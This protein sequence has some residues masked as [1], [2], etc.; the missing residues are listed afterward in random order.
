M[1]AMRTS[2][3]LLKAAPLNI[4]PCSTQISPR[5]TQIAHRLLQKKK[6][7]LRC[8]L[9]RALLNQM[10]FFFFFRSFFWLNESFLLNQ[11]SLMNITRQCVRASLSVRPSKQFFDRSENVVSEQHFWTPTNMDWNNISLDKNIL[12]ILEM[13]TSIFSTSFDFITLWSYW[14]SHMSWKQ[15]YAMEL[16]YTNRIILIILVQPNHYLQ[17]CRNAGFK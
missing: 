3:P 2:A 4:A 12:W 16:Y 5:S 6:K 8:I 1:W 17:L 15:S 13:I 9:I 14:K 11:L 7:K 10:S